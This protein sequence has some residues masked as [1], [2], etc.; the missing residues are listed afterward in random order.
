LAAKLNAGI[1]QASGFTESRLAKERERVQNFYDGFHPL[2]FTGSNSKY[3]SQDVYDAVESM[4]AQILEVFSG[5]GQPGSFPA[6]NQQDVQA[7]QIATDYVTQVIFQQN[8]GFHIFQTVLDDGLLGRAGIAKVWWE[9][10]I[11]NEAYEMSDAAIGDLHA[12]I[13]EN[14]DAHI[15]SLT[16]S[17][18]GE[19]IHRA[20][21]ELKVDK[22]YVRIEPLPPEEFLIS[23]M[24]KSI[25]EA[26]LVVHRQPKTASD[27][28]KMGY[29][30]SIVDKLQDQDEAWLST[31]PELVQ[32][33]QQ[34]DDIIGMR[35]DEMGGKARRIILV[36][37]CYTELDMDG[38][39]RTELYKVVLAG[40]TV[41]DKERVSRK[42]FCA[43]VPLP[44]PHAFWGDNYARRVMPTQSARTYLTRSIIDHTL[45]TN[46]PRYGVVRGGLANP[47]ELMENRI[48]GIVNVS[49]PDAVFPLQ[50]ASLNPYVFQ[51]INMLDSNKQSIT[52]ISDVATGLNKDVL[53]KQNS[54][55][56]VD[57]MISVS[58]IRQK[59]VARNF[60]EGFLTDL[61]REVYQL[62]CENE[63]R[64][65]IIAV[66]GSWAEIDPTTWPQRDNLE[67]DFALGY[68]ERDK[69]AQKWMMM[70]KYLGGDPA[71]A[72]LYPIDKR[73]AV[74]AKAMKY[75]GIKDIGTYLLSPQEVKPPPPN[76]MQ[77]ADLALKQADA[78]A[79][80]AAAQATSEKMKLDQQAAVLNQQ[81]EL[82]KLELQKMHIQAQIQQAQDALAHKVSTDAS[83]LMMQ[84][85]AQAQGKLT[86]VAE[87]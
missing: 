58:Q 75:Q 70:D 40:D 68:G 57:T 22:S 9:E 11:E 1:R 14:P 28:I 59:I 37:E 60:A 29:K 65:K 38:T 55:D 87:T 62:V 81:I 72:P 19:T 17:E 41:L 26:K 47:R 50:Q 4:K 20:E 56:T 34:T 53:S 5:N 86:A 51:T 77:Q 12:Y 84:Q 32:R 63:S 8:P 6:L 67:V 85:Q 10:K 7:A 16:L 31:E 2:P 83:E 52:G 64:T 71:I 78:A 82:G 3:V 61:Y 23:G 15:K 24:S 25:K 42:P 69:E 45:I 76:P 79:K 21:I 54:T 43:F 27:L 36:Y 66:S 46:N 13:S 49:R 35:N 73:Y 48:G 18:D 44:R 80:N 39:G 30:Q 74:V 33:F